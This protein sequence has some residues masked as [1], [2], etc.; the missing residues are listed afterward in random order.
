MSRHPLTPSSTARSENLEPTATPI[1]DSKSYRSF[2]GGITPAAAAHAHGIDQSTSSSSSYPYP[3]FS[4]PGLFSA[5]PLRQLHDHN[6]SDSGA[7][8]GYHA[9]SPIGSGISPAKPLDSFAA[10]SDEA[11]PASDSAPTAAAAAAKPSVAAMPLMTSAPAPSAASESLQRVTGQA[12]G[13]APSA[14][15][16]PPAAAPDPPKPTTAKSKAAMSH[17]EANA[18]LQN[19]GGAVP[20]VYLATYSNVPVYEVT[21]RGIAVMRRRNDGWLNATSILKIAGIEKTKRT[22]ILE[23]NIL[24]GEHEKIQGG[25]GKFQGTWIPLQRA[26]QLAAEHNVAHIL[27]PI[28]EFDPANA[29]QLPKLYQRRKPQPAARNTSTSAIHDGRTSATPSSTK[30]YSPAPS[31]GPTA[32]PSQQPRFLSLRPPPPEADSRSMSPAVFLPPGGGGLLNATTSVMSPAAPLA[33]PPGSSQAE[34]DA[35]RGYSQYGYVPQGV[36]LPDPAAAPGSS[37]ASRKR[38][39][40]SDSPGPAADTDGA[41]QSKRARVVSPSKGDRGDAAATAGPAADPL[42]PVKDL[43]ALGPSGGSFRAAATPRAHRMAVRNPSSRATDGSVPRYADRAIPP[44]PYDEG[45]KRMRDHLVAL[46]AEDDAAKA[47][48]PPVLAQNGTNAAATE[49]EVGAVDSRADAKPAAG[50]PAEPESYEA[51][52]DKLLQELK[53]KASL[54]GL[55]GGGSEGPKPTLD[56]V[57][58]DH[59][60]TA[61]HWA[62]ALCRLHLVRILTARPVTEGGANVHAGNHAGETALHRS[63]LVTNSY[64]ASSFPALLQLLAVSLNTRDFKKRTVLHHIALVAGLKGRAASARY[65]MACVLEFLATAGSKGGASGYAGLV[66]AQDEDG[67]TALGIVARLGNA[68]MVRMLLDVGARKDLPNALGIRP[69]DWGIEGGDAAAPTGAGR[70]PPATAHELATALPH[71]IVAALGR[72]AQGPVLKS[73]DVKERMGAALEE[74]QVAFERELKEK[75]DAVDVVQGHLHAATRDLAARRRN[76]SAA[77]ARVAEKDEAKQRVRNLRRALGEHLGVSHEDAVFQQKADALVRLANE[78]RDQKPKSSPVD[79]NGAS[80]SA[81]ELEVPLASVHADMQASKVEDEQE[82]VEVEELVRLR[83]LVQWY[84][85]SCDELQHRIEGLEGASAT[86]EKQ[87]QQV[88]AMCANVPQDKV[89]SMLDDLLTAMESDGQEVDLARVAN[90][91]QK[92]GKIPSSGGGAPAPSGPAAAASAAAR[93]SSRPATLTPPLPPPAA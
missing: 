25:Y 1:T 90:F 2:A 74:V 14:S 47:K 45:E 59:G 49:R 78:L 72:P 30:T 21:V 42:A 51:K 38:A 69:A 82:A 92:V 61:L 20:T 86:K 22:K 44:K 18:A 60:H 62:S 29:D 43:N 48:G 10:S 6:L 26:Q 93:P 77:Q 73:S 40:P 58:D 83:W 16:P 39:G 37:T 67:E 41:S 23:K 27:K 32:G 80:A 68:S 11:V 57:T 28:L 85:Q 75:Q 53:E 64:D 54:G 76:V 9:L 66:D 19:S 50:G 5:T 12:A 17:A 8:Y 46:F 87:C 63:V 79:G 7:P 15:N 24:T 65:Y 13:A 4:T 34:Q 33:I 70:L 36:P 55:G 35:L 84:G 3:S 81:D 91:M 88:V 52:L 71:D 31:V 56:L 89:E